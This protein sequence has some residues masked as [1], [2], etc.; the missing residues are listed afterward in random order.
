MQIATCKLQI[1]IAWDEDIGRWRIQYLLFNILPNY[2][3]QS[4]Y[5]T[6]RDHL[7]DHYVSE[8][9]TENTWQTKDG[10]TGFK[11]NARK[12]MIPCKI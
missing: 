9:H 2:V 5:Q 4:P 12:K 10:E 8:F 6:P 7:Q 11:K 1:D 3:L